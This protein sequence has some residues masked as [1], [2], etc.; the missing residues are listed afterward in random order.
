MAACNVGTYGPQFDNSQMI[1]AFYSYTQGNLNL[2][3]EV[4]YQYAKANAKIGLFKPSSNFGRGC[5]CGLYLRH[6]TLLDRWLG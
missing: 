3:P 5:V 2:V 1:G 6:V 4:Q